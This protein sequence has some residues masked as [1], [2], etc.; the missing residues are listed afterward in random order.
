MAVE[1]HRPKREAHRDIVRTRLRPMEFAESVGASKSQ[2]YAWIYSGRLKA[3]QQGRAWFIPITE[4]TE[5]F[6]REAA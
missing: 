1:V 6:E 2:V 5:F 4:L 3:V